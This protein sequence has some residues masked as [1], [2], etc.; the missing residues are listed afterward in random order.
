M[1]KASRLCWKLCNKK[2][3][4][5]FEYAAEEAHEESKILRELLSEAFLHGAIEENVAALEMYLE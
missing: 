4:L 1:V 3:P 5:R 2:R